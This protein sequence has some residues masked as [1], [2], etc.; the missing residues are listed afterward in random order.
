MFQIQLKWN[1][2]VIETV[3]AADYNSGKFLIA[4]D[5]GEFEWVDIDN[6]YL[7]KEEDQ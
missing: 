5:W 2:R 1:E 6:Y 4:T 7:Y 3:Y